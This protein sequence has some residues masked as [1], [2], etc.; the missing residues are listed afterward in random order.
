MAVQLRAIVLHTEAERVTLLSSVPAISARSDVIHSCGIICRS[1]G[2]TTWLCTDADLQQVFQVLDQAQDFNALARLLL[3][4]I[5][6]APA[7]NLAP[8]LAVAKDVLPRHYHLRTCEACH[9]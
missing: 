2:D 8:L 9:H 3:F 6:C 1:G 7:T 5:N 4:L